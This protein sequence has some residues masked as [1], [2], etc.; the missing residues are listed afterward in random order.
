MVIARSTGFDLVSGR[1]LTA[2][3]IGVDAVIDVS[4][5]GTLSGKKSIMF[6]EAATNNLLAAERAAGVRHHVA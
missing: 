2:A 5:I 3:L 6:F 1:G 4:S